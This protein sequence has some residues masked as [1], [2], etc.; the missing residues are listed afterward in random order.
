MSLTIIERP[1]H[2]NNWSLR[3]P[4]VII[5]TIVLHDTGGKTAESALRWFENPQ[6]HVSSHYVVDLDGTL[7]RPVR[8]DDKAWHAGQSALWGETDL[9][10]CSIGIEIVDDDDHEPYPP[11]Q[12][13]SVVELTT[14]I[15][16]RR[17]I[18]LNRI[19]GHEHISLPPGRK[20]D[21]SKDFKWSP[22]LLAVA[23]HVNAQLRRDYQT[24]KGH[25]P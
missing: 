21:P 22:F 15:V 1:A 4:G 9:N 3:P 20:V 24:M 6:A 2:K 12:L 10:Q 18:W 5:D 19:V 25:A 13:R 16:V 11:A 7:Y 14:E 23:H 17:A 8:E